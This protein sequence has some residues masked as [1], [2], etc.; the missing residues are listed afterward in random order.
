MDSDGSALHSDIE[1]DQGSDEKHVD[2]YNESDTDVDVPDPNMENEPLYQDVDCMPVPLRPSH[3]EVGLLYTMTLEQKRYNPMLVWIVEAKER[4]FS[5]QCYFN[6]VSK[7]KSWHE[8]G[9]NNTCTYS[10]VWRL[11]PRREL[12]RTCDPGKAY[13][14]QTLR[15]TYGMTT[16]PVVITVMRFTAR[17]LKGIVVCGPRRGNQDS[18]NIFEII[19]CTEVFGSTLLH[20]L[21]TK[22][23][24][25]K[26]S[27]GGKTKTRPISERKPRLSQEF[28]VPANEDT[29]RVWHLLK[30]I[31]EE[32]VELLIHRTNKRA[33]RRLSRRSNAYSKRWKNLS[34]ERLRAFLGA[35]F[36]V[37]ILRV[38]LRHL[39]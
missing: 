4:S 14:G 13:I 31:G 29:K 23:K 33:E 12:V 5:Y 9:K 37:S 16:S 35:R 8:T 6:L 3:F 38:S 39:T 32:G 10:G 21:L 22:A 25:A 26:W 36:G 20:N 7:A 15:F 11:A 1:S 28:H 24:E 2:W 18:W 30:I 34:K 27:S 19:G 17:V